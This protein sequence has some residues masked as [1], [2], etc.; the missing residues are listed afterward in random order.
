MWF[1]IS[2]VYYLASTTTSVRSTPVINFNDVIIPNPQQGPELGGGLGPIGSTRREP[3]QPV[4][5]TLHDDDY[6]TDT[7]EEERSDMV[8]LLNRY[9]PVFKLSYVVFVDVAPLRW[10]AYWVEG[11]VG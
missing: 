5:S 1:L 10:Y 3:G 4:Y 7:E 9:A 6:P 2:L 8:E 11:M